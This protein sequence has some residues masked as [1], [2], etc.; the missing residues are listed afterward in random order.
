MLKFTLMHLSPN[1]QFW[2][3]PNT[4]VLRAWP[5]YL[6][7]PFCSIVN[8]AK[9]LEQGR[10]SSLLFQIHAFLSKCSRNI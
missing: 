7:L 5:S 8:T 9:N 1:A 4:L 3:G 2:N 10:E 6:A